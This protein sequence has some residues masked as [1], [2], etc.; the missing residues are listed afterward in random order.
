[1]L[2]GFAAVA[3]AGGAGFPIALAEQAAEHPFAP[4]FPVGSRAALP[5]DGMTAVE[6]EAALRTGGNGL[7]AGHF[8]VS[9]CEGWSI[10]TA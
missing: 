3:L 8:S 9:R 2:A 10:G 7:F 5:V 4:D 1:M 6:I